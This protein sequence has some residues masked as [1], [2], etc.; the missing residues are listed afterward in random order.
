MGYKK[1]VRFS[2][3]CFRGR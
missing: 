2:Q 3:L 1:L